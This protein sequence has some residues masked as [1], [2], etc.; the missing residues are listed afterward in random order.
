LPRQ[1]AAANTAFGYISPDRAGLTGKIFSAAA[2]RCADHASGA[3]RS[4]LPNSISPARL[5][6]RWFQHGLDDFEAHAEALQPCREGPAQVMEPA[7]G[8][9][10]LRCRASTSLSTAARSRQSGALKIT[11]GE[12]VMSVLN[13]RRA[14]LSKKAKKS[15]RD[16]HFPIQ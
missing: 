11:S 2:R 7:A 10:G 6:L 14:C 8:I 12:P 3:A 9:T 4:P 16:G 1:S 5:P 13:A 15:F